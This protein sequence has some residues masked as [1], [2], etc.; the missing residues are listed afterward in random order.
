MTTE[1]LSAITKA[2]Y[3]SAELFKEK[4]PE[5]LGKLGFSEEKAKFLQA[6]IEVDPSRGAG[7]AMEAGR[8]ED[9]STSA[10]QELALTAWI[11]KD[12]TL[13]YMNSA[14][15]SNKPTRCIV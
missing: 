9:Q 1:K 4:M 10:Y 7:H 14:T 6:N 15:M 12:T 11:I 13:R 8:R 5:L 3:P 2:K